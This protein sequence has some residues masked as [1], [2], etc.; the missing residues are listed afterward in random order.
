MK[1]DAIRN[2][3]SF[4]S[5]KS[6]TSE[7]AAALSAQLP[8]A[9]TETSR[10]ISVSSAEEADSAKTDSSFS[11][12]EEAKNLVSEEHAAIAAM[13]SL[14]SLPSSTSSSS[15]SL[16]VQGKKAEE[17]KPVKVASAASKAH[18]YAAAPHWHQGAYAHA[19]YPPHMMMPAYRPYPPPASLHPMAAVQAAYRNAP[20]AHQS[21]R[22]A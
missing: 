14:K 16:K 5:L 7:E 19:G 21:Y 15:N 8:R 20:Y 18:P 6:H 4:D 1:K 12:K 17:K 11:A 13:L 9:L 22:R 2:C 10:I 3:V